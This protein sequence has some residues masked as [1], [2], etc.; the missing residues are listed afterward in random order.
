[1]DNGTILAIWAVGV[2]VIL[3]VGSYLSL[4][5]PRYIREAER[6]AARAWRKYDESE[7]RA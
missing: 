7:V 3:G 1:M 4:R 5:R 6:V 2:V